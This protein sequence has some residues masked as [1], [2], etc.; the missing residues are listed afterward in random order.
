MNILFVCTGNTCRSP[1]AEGFF[2]HLCKVNTPKKLIN[3]QSA[4]TGAADGCGASENAIKVLDELGINLR[5]HRSQKLTSTL[6][7]W[8]DLA[9]AMTQNHFSNIR[10]LALQIEKK[11]E[12]KLLSEFSDK[13]LGISDPFGGNLEIYKDC[14]CEMKKHLC[15]LYARIEKN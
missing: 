12:I 15:N 3:I 4:G 1:M 2:R 9:I 6:L 5:N 14:F 11:P 7:E 8:S 13:S 10:N